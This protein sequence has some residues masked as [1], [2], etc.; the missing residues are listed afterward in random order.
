[1]NQEETGQALA[2][3][4]EN[5]RKDGP[6]ATKVTLA[7]WHR[8]LEDLPFKLVEAS[9]LKLIL[10]GP[11]FCPKISEVR[12]HALAM[13]CDEKEMPRPA[14]AWEMVRRALYDDE[15]SERAWNELPPAVMAAANAI[16]L[17]ELRNGE[18]AV[19]R[20]H[21]LKFYEP[22][23]EAALQEY[24]LPTTFMVLRSELREQYGVKRLPAAAQVER[25]GGQ[26][27][28]LQQPMEEMTPQTRERWAKVRQM[29]TELTEHKSMWL[30]DA[31]AVHST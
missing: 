3:L 30:R 25:A 23:R 16:G 18:S 14:E 13:I 20:A 10:S 1:M 31:D 24:Q 5:W 22:E 29:I 8:C 6:A 9:I 2:L 26:P 21:F 15:W 28:A 11:P 27:A 7:L 12:R 17:Y 19:N 4:A